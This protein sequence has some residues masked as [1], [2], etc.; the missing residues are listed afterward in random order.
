M[1]EGG[2][3][4]VAKR[5]SK[6]KKLLGIRARYRVYENIISIGDTSET[7]MPDRKPR[8]ASSETDMPYRRLT[9]RIGDPLEINMPVESNRNFNTYIFK[10]S[11]FFILFAYLYILE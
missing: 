10:Y 2:G 6:T 1:R 7:D 11:Y 3:G 4:A 8:H 9:C 5:I